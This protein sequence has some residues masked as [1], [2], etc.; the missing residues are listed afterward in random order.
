MRINIG[1]GNC[2]L[3]I[4]WKSAIVTILF[5]QIGCAAV[6]QTPAENTA[7]G[8]VQNTTG[9]KNYGEIHPDAPPELAQFGRL[10][11]RWQCAMSERRSDG[12]WR[13]RA[14]PVV[15]TWFYTLNGWAVQDIWTPVD[16]PGDRQPIATNLRLYSPSTQQWNVSWTN[17][18][19]ASFELWSGVQENDEI[20]LNSLRDRRPVRI[21]FFN[22]L[23][24]QFQWS[25]SAAASLSSEEFTD[26]LQM[27]C[28][29][30][31]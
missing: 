26:V 16:V 5:L 25:Y 14:A 22:F 24:R 20:V 18:Q 9:A 4:M 29:S 15:W 6:P 31:D 10:A 7:A 11:G 30:L 27:Q 2:C 23:P 3:S 13:S 12:S 8:S 17:T 21:R 28:T 19:Q 1:R